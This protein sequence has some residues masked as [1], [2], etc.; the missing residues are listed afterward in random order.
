MSMTPVN[1]M[2]YATMF[3]LVTIVLVLS[4]LEVWYSDIIR[5]VT[6]TISAI[7]AGQTMQ[8]TK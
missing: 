4:I 7:A 6:Y 5:P 1:T 8:D 3:M 2:A